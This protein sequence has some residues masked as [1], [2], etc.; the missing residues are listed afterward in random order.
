MDAAHYKPKKRDD[1]VD[2]LG[3]FSQPAHVPAQPRA[4]SEAAAVEISK[5]LPEK[6][7]AVFVAIC[8]HYETRRRGISHNGLIRHFADRGWSVN[9]PRARAIELYK[10]GLIEEDGEANGST[11]WAPSPLG[12]EVYLEIVHH[13]EAA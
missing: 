12:W 1:G 3:L 7:R 4:T 13:P 10:A 5:S 2:G 9:T 11:L 8:Q 6:R